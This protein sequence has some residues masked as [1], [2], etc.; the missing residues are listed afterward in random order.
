MH[1]AEISADGPHLLDAGAVAEARG[2]NPRATG[3]LEAVVDDIGVFAR[4]GL[5]MRR[6]AS[7]RR[8]VW[9][10]C[11]GRRQEVRLASQCRRS[12]MRMLKP[13]LR[14]MGVPRAWR[15]EGS[16]RPRPLVS[17]PPLTRSWF[18]CSVRLSVCLVF[19]AR[20]CVGVLG[21]PTADAV[22]GVEVLGVGV[23]EGVEVFLGGGDLRVAHP[24]HHGLEVGPA[25]EEPGG[26]G[27]AEVVDADVEVDAGGFDGGS[28]DA[29]A[30]G[31]A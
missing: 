19:R 27:V 22:E 26:V 30:E 7:R 14:E 31:V 3:N 11:V 20:G 23:G 15:T 9:L 13:I 2:S 16:P 29:G 17:A 18:G 1:L 24:V 8:H 6:R 25:G 28:P 4:G 10:V 5:A 21:L 12:W